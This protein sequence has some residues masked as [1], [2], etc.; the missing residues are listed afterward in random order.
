ME[1]KDETYVTSDNMSLGVGL[2]KEDL[3]IVFF[4][5]SRSF[6]DKNREKFDSYIKDNCEYYDTVIEHKRVWKID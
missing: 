5:V 6:F 4:N 2:Y 3:L 1:P